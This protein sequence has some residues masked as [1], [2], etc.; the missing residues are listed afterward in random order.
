MKSYLG[1][2]GSAPG[3]HSRQS[4]ARSCQ[5]PEPVRALVDLVDARVANELLHAT[6]CPMSADAFVQVPVTC[7][8][9]ERLRTL[10]ERDGMAES[11]RRPS[12]T[13]QNAALPTACHAVQS[14]G[15]IGR[16]L[17]PL[18]RQRE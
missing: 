6:L 7:E 15:E 10:A 8:T 1:D 17:L 18:L 14:F 9:K 5:P 4:C 11:A 13:G 12:A 2:E 16:F 3:R